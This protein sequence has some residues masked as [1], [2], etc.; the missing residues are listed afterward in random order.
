ML[1][2]G[3]RLDSLFELAVL[4]GE[5]VWLPCPCTADMGVGIDPEVPFRPG[6]V[7]DGSGPLAMASA[8][9]SVAIVPILDRGSL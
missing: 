6:V 1:F 7:A 8:L 5:G 2:R 9:T 3:G 4:D